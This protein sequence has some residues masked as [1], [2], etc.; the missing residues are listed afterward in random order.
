M[1]LTPLIDLAVLPLRIVARAQ[2][3]IALPEHAGSR[4]RGAFGAALKELVCVHRELPECAPC[5]LLPACAYPA[6][7][8]PR[9]A[10]GEHGAAGFEDLPRPYVIRAGP[11]GQQARAGEPLIWHVTLIG[12]AISQ[13]AYFVLAWQAMGQRGLGPERGRFEL[14][15]VEALD[16]NGQGR[17]VLYDR[18]SNRVRGASA[19]VDVEQLATWSARSADQA[20]GVELTFLTPTLLKQRGQPVTEPLFHLVWRAVQRRLSVLR[21]AHGAG[22]PAVDFAASIQQAEAIRLTGW[23]GEEVSWTRYS[24]RQK[25]SVPMGGFIGV[26]HYTGEVAPFLTALKLG[27]LVGIGDNCTFGQGEYKLF[28]SRVG[29]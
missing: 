19:P 9:A 10:A 11:G 24:R 1:E 6:L 23:S 4:L 20:R 25:Q 21:L 2:D 29:V 7:F 5:P 17:E 26:A 18:E 8:E 14:I 16:L 28:V 15:G 22:R 3:P 27:T 13:F 12:R